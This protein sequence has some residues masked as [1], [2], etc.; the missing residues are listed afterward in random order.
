MLFLYSSL[1][2]IYA[3]LDNGQSVISVNQWTILFSPAL[4]KKCIKTPVPVGKHVPHGNRR[5][6]TFTS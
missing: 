4:R 6:R 5:A 1:R 3:R 2:E